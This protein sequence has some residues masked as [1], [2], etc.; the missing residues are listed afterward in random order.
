MRTSPDHF[1]AK[2]RDELEEALAGRTALVT[3]ADGSWARVSPRRNLARGGPIR[4]LR[5]NLAR[6]GTG[7]GG[8]LVLGGALCPTPAEIAV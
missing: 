5:P 4:V 6:A 1:L 2:R 8:R 7:T 3:D